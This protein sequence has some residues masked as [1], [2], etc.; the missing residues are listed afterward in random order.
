MIQN[1]NGQ[2]FLETKTIATILKHIGITNIP[3]LEVCDTLILAIYVS[4]IIVVLKETGRKTAIHSIP[5]S[6]T[7]HSAVF[8]ASH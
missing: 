3:S 1:F 7:E 2:R 8:N 6:T 4:S 5:Y